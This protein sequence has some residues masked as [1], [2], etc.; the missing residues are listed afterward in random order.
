MVKTELSP[1]V[2]EK[3]MTVAE[4]FRAEGVEQNRLEIAKRLLAKNA[5]LSFIEE[6]TGLPLIK[7]KEL[8]KNH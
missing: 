7:I 6:V 3:I 8:Q 5:E 2:G 4:Q 1:E